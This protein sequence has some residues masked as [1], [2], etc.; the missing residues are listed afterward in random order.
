M[1]PL[2]ARI[3]ELPVRALHLDRDLPSFE[4]VA[5]RRL[6]SPYERGERAVGIDP[7]RVGD[8]VEVAFEAVATLH[9]H[10]RTETRQPGLETRV[11]GV[12]VLQHDQL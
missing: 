9:R 5:D 3:H 10:P 12:K 7:Q 1:L 11:Y 4:G 8:G 2:R 6:R